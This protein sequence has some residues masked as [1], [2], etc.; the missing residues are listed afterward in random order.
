M[1]SSGSGLEAIRTRYGDHVTALSSQKLAP[2]WPISGDG[3]VGTVRLLTRCAEFNN[4]II[5]IIIII[6]INGTTGHCW[7]LAT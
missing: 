1:Q 4:I 7:V 5:I 2:T 6:I 3:S